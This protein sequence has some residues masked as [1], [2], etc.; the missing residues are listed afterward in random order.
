MYLKSIL[1]VGFKSF[2]DKTSMEFTPGVTAIVGPNGC[3][4]SNVS[5][6]I[7]WVLGEQSARALRGGEMAD[8]I[9]SGTESGRKPLSLAEV[10]L[11]FADCKEVLRTGQIAGIDV[12][13]D[14]V[15]VTRRIFRDGNSDYFI[16]KTA[17]RLRD[18]QS[19]FMDTGIGRSSYS[20]MEQGKIDKILSSH[21]EDRRSVFEEAAGITRYKSQKREALRK[22]EYTE[23]NMTRLSDTIREVKRQINSL[24]RQA[25]KAR[26]YQALSAEMRHLDTQLAR[27]RYEEMQAACEEAQRA[28]DEARDGLVKGRAEIEAGERAV[29]SLRTRAE[30]AEVRRQAVLQKR[31]DL[32]VQ[33][34]RCEER[35]RST[36]ERSAE[37]RTTIEA[38]ERECGEARAR[39][40][41]THA[42]EAGI[43]Q[44]LD[45]LKAERDRRQGDVA[46]V[47]ADLDAALARERGQESLIQ[48]CQDE[49]LAAEGELI[50]LRN[51]EVGLERQRQEL[52][53]GAQKLAAERGASVGQQ[54]TLLQ[55]QDA[56]QS[57]LEAFKQTFESSRHAL[58][59][60]EEAL[61]EA[62][63]KCTSLAGEVSELQ[64]AL[65]D[66]RSR[67]EVLR[68]L[69][70]TYEGYSEGA[71]ALL[72]GHYAEMGEEVRRAILGTLADLI[73]VEPRYAVAIEA[74]LGQGLQAIVLSEASAALRLVEALQ[75][76]NLGRA[77][78]AIKEEEEGL[79]GVPMAAR[80]R[81]EGALC[82][83]SDAVQCKPLVHSLVRNLLADM[84]IVPDV[85]IAL[86]L[87]RKDPGL[88]LVTVEGDVLDHHGILCAGSAKAL[89]LQV[90]GRR[91]EIV[92][93]D[94]E[95]GE[96]EVRLRDLGAQKGE[97]EG[98]RAAARQSL[99]DRQ[100]ELRTRETDLSGKLLLLNTLQAEVRDIESRLAVA[101][102]AAK[103]MNQR[104]AE[105]ATEQDR[106]RVATSVAVERQ[107]RAKEALASA[108]SVLDE[109]SAASLRHQ[110]AVTDLQVAMATTIEQLSGCDG[111]IRLLER[112]A[113]ETDQLLQAR[114]VAIRDSQQ[115]LVQWEGDIA[116]T[117]NRAAALK[118]SLAGIGAEEASAEN[119]KRAAV[120]QIESAAE[121]LRE[122][123]ERVESVQRK[124]TDL[125][126]RLTERR[127][128]S[129]HLV[130]RIQR[131]HAADLVGIS[132]LALKVA[133]APLPEP[134]PTPVEEP[135][136]AL[137]E[138]PPSAVADYA[139]PEDLPFES[140]DAVAA[141]VEEVRAKLQ[142]I[143]PVSLEA[144]QE[145]Q[146]QEDRHRFLTQQFDDLSASKENLTAL[147]RKINIETRRMFGETFEKIRANFQQIFSELF[148]GGKADL[149]LVDGD[150]PLE[151][152]IDIMARPPGKQL[153]NISL[154]S[155]GER[156]MTAVS[157]LFAIYMVKPSP[158]CVLDEMDAPLDESNIGR[159]T[160]MLQR[161]LHQSQFLIITHNKR[162]I[163]M[164]DALYG[165]TMEERGVSKLVSV[166][167][168]PRTTE[169]EK[170]ARAPAEA[171]AAGFEK[172]RGSSQAT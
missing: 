84:V 77:T 18:V 57:E 130:E 1:L 26:R 91:N 20:I 82:W 49:A 132:L 24:Q 11:T 163:G 143:G 120:E 74:G 157:L 162:T 100:T 22:L 54:R 68:Q 39:L 116:E 146:E 137:A 131:E 86:D 71:R 135:A 35:V 70:D 4:K 144:V 118:V 107:A 43:R 50:N 40:A 117:E 8:V 149:A 103:E 172:D 87:H 33:V 69:H 29:T 53:L 72:A 16:N 25:S 167:F 31:R 89:P 152:G 9:F 99:G 123:R 141:R 134:T 48:K 27:R 112:R 159:F 142:S 60:G 55:R 83:A 155:G 164:A 75:R 105:S 5:D 122:A 79:G 45:S 81:P 102:L 92:A 28:L 151:C 52:A 23:A 78:F 110:A 133:G 73:E 96:R 44:R 90:L 42:H 36:R 47:R 126:V 14:E 113:S 93:L 76:R 95:I 138:L 56:L 19:L 136:S 129:A 145:Y 140:W 15:T 97:W 171:E 160:G 59:G 7:R 62:D 3:G 80:L 38:A 121:K 119:E 2:A 124:L 128:E 85:Q 17:C 139:P 6:A 58:S 34:E 106:V 156:T 154:L 108:K 168:R 98:R 101:D 63:Q 125:E 61:R 153:Q 150:D 115:K 148:G 12:N 66:R 127:T 158:F 161:F 169:E 94:L 65:S 104:C 147:I 166:R 114:Q 51:Q 21:P 170:V 41:E 64:T 46:K 67:H 109:V 111:E 10:S 165:V 32:E 88:T 30:E 13:F 37:A